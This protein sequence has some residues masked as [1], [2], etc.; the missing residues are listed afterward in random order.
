MKKQWQL[1]Q[2]GIPVIGVSALITVTLRRESDGAI[3]DFDDTTFKLSGWSTPTAPMS[4][5]NASLLPGWYE[6]SQSHT[7]WQDDTYQVSAVYTGTPSEYAVGER[8]IKNGDIIEQAIYTLAGTLATATAVSTIDTVV[9]AIKLKTDTIPA[10]PA[11]V[12]KQDAILA[13]V[14]V[15]SAGSGLRDISVSLCETGTTDAIAAATVTAYFGGELMARQTTDANG[16]CTLHLNDGAYAL[17][18]SK[19][20]VAFATDETLTVSAD[21]AV[22]VYGTPIVL[23]AAPTAEQCTVYEYCFDQPSQTPLASVTAIA[24]ILPVAD[25]YGRTHQVASVAGTYN[26][27]TG[28]VYWYIV[29]GAKV[30]VKID[31]TGVFETFTVPDAA[32]V[33]VMGHPA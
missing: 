29:R 32:N 5:V 26:S 27:T 13:S 14:A 33:R 6:F 25:V 31:E 4:E 23:P 22:T 9:D 8:V 20:G 30:R 21:A 11:T 12:T 7:G 24:T 17:R 19:P 28:I 15:I 18:L 1:V 16:R 3:F 10:D 2:D